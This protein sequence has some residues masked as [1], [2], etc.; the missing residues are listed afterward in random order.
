M[1]HFFSEHATLSSAIRKK[2]SIP[3]TAVIGPI[4]HIYEPTTHMLKLE[5]SPFASSLHHSP[6][7]RSDEAVGIGFRIKKMLTS[8]VISIAS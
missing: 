1:K 7:A 6:N 8:A 5:T 2:H 4:Y 3:G